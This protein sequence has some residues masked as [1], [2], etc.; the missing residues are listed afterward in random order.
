VCPDASSFD[1]IYSQMEARPRGTY[2]FIDIGLYELGFRAECAK[3]L[4]QLLA[5]VGSP[6]G[7]ND[8]CAFTGEGQRGGAANASQRTSDQNDRMGRHCLSLAKFAK[9]ADGAAQ[10]LEPASVLVPDFWLKRAC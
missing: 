6:P 1:A 5:F 2:V 8:M 10:R 4:S 3:R 9:A 7:D